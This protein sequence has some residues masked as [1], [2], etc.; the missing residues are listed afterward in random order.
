MIE[1]AIK[2]ENDLLETLKRIVVFSDDVK[3]A[4]KILRSL[5]E[6]PSVDYDSLYAETQKIGLSSL[7][8]YIVDLLM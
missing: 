6:R 5:S 3:S 4:I 8:T 7:F 2:N 1:S